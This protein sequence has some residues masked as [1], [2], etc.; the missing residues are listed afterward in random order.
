MYD[1]LIY[2]DPSQSI[3]DTSEN[4]HTNQLNLHLWTMSSKHF[5]KRRR[6]RDKCCVEE[7]KILFCKHRQV[8][9]LPT[10]EYLSLIF[11][12]LLLMLSQL[13]DSQLI[14][15][16]PRSNLSSTGSHSHDDL[17][18][19]LS[20]TMLLENLL[21]HPSPINRSRLSL[22]FPFSSIPPYEDS[23]T[24]GQKPSN[25]TDQADRTRNSSKK[26]KLHDIKR[27]LPLATPSMDVS[28]TNRSNT[29]IEDK[30]VED[31]KANK[32]A[33]TTPDSFNPNSLNY[34]VDKLLNIDSSKQQATQP[35]RR[36]SPRPSLI[37][38]D[39]PRRTF[40]SSSGPALTLDTL[41]K[42]EYDSRVQPM[43]KLLR[44]QQKLSTTNS[45]RRATT[46]LPT[47][48]PINHRPDDNMNS[49][50]ATINLM[51]NNQ[52]TT[53]LPH[54]SVTTTTTTNSPNE[55]TIIV[56]GSNRP[57]PPRSEG[58]RVDD[59]DSDNM[60]EFEDDEEEEE[61]EQAT[62]STVTD[63]TGPT[64]RLT[65]VPPYQLGTNFVHQPSSD[66]T[67]KDTERVMNEAAFIE[68]SSR[69]DGVVGGSQVGERATDASTRGSMVFSDGGDEAE[70]ANKRK[71]SMFD[72]RADDRPTTT[73]H[74]SGNFVTKASST[75]SDKLGD[76]FL[77]N[78]LFSTVNPLID[79][80]IKLRDSGP[81]TT[82]SSHDSLHGQIGNPLI[83]KGYVGKDDYLFSTTAGDWSRPLG[84]S[85][86]TTTHKY[87]HPNLTPT[88]RMTTTTTTTPAPPTEPPTVPYNY[89]LHQPVTNAQ[90]VPSMVIPTSDPVQV[91][92]TAPTPF[93]AIDLA[94]ETNAKGHTRPIPSP[95]SSQEYSSNRHTSSNKSASNKFLSSADKSP[96]IIV[97]DR[98]YSYQLPDRSLS[99]HKSQVRH[100]STNSLSV[101]N[102]SKSH[103]SESETNR[104]TSSR[105]NDNV[106]STTTSGANQK[107]SWAPTRL[108]SSRRDENQVQADNS[109]GRQ[110][111]HT[112][113]LLVNNRDSSLSFPIV[114]A[115]SSS[116]SSSSRQPIQRDSTNS[117][118][119]NSTE[120]AD[121]E[122]D[123]QDSFVSRRKP[124]GDLSRPI[125]FGGRNESNNIA[126]QDDEQPQLVRKT[127]FNS[128]RNKSK[129]STTLR[130]RP[131]DT[132]QETS[133]GV[134]D[135][136]YSNRNNE[137]SSSDSDQENSPNV[138][139]EEANA[140][141]DTGEMSDET[142]A[143][144]GKNNANW[145]RLRVQSGNQHLNSTGAS[146]RR[147]IK[148]VNQ[149]ISHEPAGSEIQTTGVQQQNFSGLLPTQNH[150]I[151]VV[152]FNRQPISPSRSTETILIGGGGGT[153]GTYAIP[154]TPAVLD[155]QTTNYGSTIGQGG[156]FFGEAS[157]ERPV[158][159][160][161][162][163]LLTGDMLAGKPG[164]H[165]GGILV[166]KDPYQHHS[167]NNILSSIQ[168]PP[169]ST[170]LAPKGSTTTS[171]V[172][173][174]TGS[175][176][177]NV[178]GK[179]V[180][181][182]NQTVLLLIG[183]SCVV[184]V[185]CLLLAA[186]R[187]Q[188]V[189]DDYR[190]LRNAE[191]AAL[192]LQKHRLRYTKSHQINRLSR[193]LSS[194]E[195]GRSLIDELNLEQPNS[196]VDLAAELNQ[197]RNARQ[198]QQ[199][200]HLTR[201]MQFQPFAKNVSSAVNNNNNNNDQLVWSAANYRLPISSSL[202]DN[203]KESWPCENANH[204]HHQHRL[205]CQDDLM[206]GVNNNSK[207]WMHPYQFM[208][209]H[210]HHHHQTRL[211][212][213]FGAGS[214]VSTFFPRRHDGHSFRNLGGSMDAQILVDSQQHSCAHA[215]QQQL[216]R[217]LTRSK[218]I[219]FDANKN[220]GRHVECNNPEHNHS[221]SHH[222]CHNHTNHKCN[223]HH[224]H[225]HHHQQQHYAVNNTV[226][227]NST[228]EDSE[229]TFD[230]SQ[231]VH[232]DNG[233]HGCNQGLNA[234][235]KAI[236]IAKLN[237]QL[238]S[239]WK[240][241]QQAR[242]VASSSSLHHKDH[243]HHHQRHQHHHHH[244]HHGRHQQQTTT[245]GSDSSSPTQCTCSRDH[246]PL[247]VAH[248]VRSN[249][250]KT[251]H[252]HLSHR[253][254]SKASLKQQ[255]KRDKSMLIWSTNRDRL[256]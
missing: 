71:Q 19:R 90:S 33:T 168:Q 111:N 65:N 35:H 98:K 84:N 94:R 26:V 217:G 176:G 57:P 157:S 67:P 50:E 143:Q 58:N 232:C 169:T 109:L 112:N 156:N 205:M 64:K 61:E 195:S 116:S 95:S 173:P 100:N 202:V 34:L 207:S 87:L 18:R 192:K 22:I 121:V 30:N 106:T 20:S 155:H 108:D 79:L 47:T 44:E 48:S 244:H 227:D 185:V 184:S 161:S 62:N 248:N 59:F 10:M 167:S 92:T 91:T 41:I 160:N 123:S 190:S 216:S 203:N 170:T 82:S 74:D 253:H 86:D 222:I 114:E 73:T 118:V 140:T 220:V 16:R 150:T 194:A 2:Q 151:R 247:L 181:S 49:S 52:P 29:V 193:G 27:K 252:K 256:I 68:S 237:N 180:K 122:H 133:S 117:Q 230:D 183:I 165:S 134:D 210:Q 103:Q 147:P 146:N 9:S 223:H 191:R 164:Q 63:K 89:F 189:C 171:D 166:T 85:R 235:L 158:M 188:D 130:H 152:Q 197:A 142:G 25:S 201:S 5:R 8:S 139:Q 212:P 136:R 254:D 149:F 42:N 208:Q 54:E 83:Y 219:L 55:E 178:A 32:Q 46:S 124:A 206:V 69:P 129:V 17:L 6:K 43:I 250:H 12:C 14:L 110:A 21:T 153:D 132:D 99:S 231:A 221:Q 7:A 51:T 234:R 245:T 115:K 77:L 53:L 186:M 236:Q 127:K 255:A 240:K 11:T 125:K 78:Q 1:E 163:N 31:E 228:S 204:Q 37:K 233:G 135:V 138:D 13:V 209:Q 39:H 70:R 172:D 56:T 241:Q 215:D 196:S 101:P 105:L 23:K 211:R 119:S 148:R 38:S 72:D 251:S 128:E 88:I 137:A 15:D 154:S 75:K 76:S 226:A 126:E 159:D 96:K 145:P 113:V 246:Q 28:T 97:N 200:N 80:N 229:L 238:S 131:S 179:T 3:H 174:Q 144:R 182:T 175:G 93:A 40:N 60:D 187:C 162:I 24:I 45:A 177:Q 102:F 81:A 141:G 249:L 218:S 239:V 120:Q 4:C 225:L 36:P 104:V 66:Q 242:K 243:H 107:G 199:Q 214:S 198:Q 224:H 213:L